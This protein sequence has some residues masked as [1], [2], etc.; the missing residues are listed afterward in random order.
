MKN[1]MQKTNKLISQGS[2]ELLVVVVILF[3]FILGI[4]DIALYFRQVYV[5]QTISDEVLARLKTAS[6][7]YYEAGSYDSRTFSGEYTEENV[8]NRVKSIM[9][10]AIKYYY[11]KDVDFSVLVNPSTNKIAAYKSPDNVFVFNVYCSK[12]STPDYV[13]FSHLYKGMFLYPNGKRLYSNLSTNTT[14]F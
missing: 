5:V 1:K 4:M 11:N 9:K 7:C 3:I 8:Q 2:I 14:L 12:T 13:Y 6:V 10:K